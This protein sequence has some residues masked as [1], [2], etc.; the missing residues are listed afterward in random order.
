[1]QIESVNIK[2]KIQNNFE[3]LFVKGALEN[4][5]FKLCFNFCTLLHQF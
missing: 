3:L 1:M 5:N 4:Y 2:K